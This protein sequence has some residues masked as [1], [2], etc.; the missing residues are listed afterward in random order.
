LS[1]VTDKPNRQETTLF[2]EDEVLVRM[3]IAQY[4]RDCGYRVIEAANADEAMTVLMQAGGVPGGLVSI[5]RHVVNHLGM[6]LAAAR[7]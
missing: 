6:R 2:V 1:R 3:P 4:L 7:R 5:V